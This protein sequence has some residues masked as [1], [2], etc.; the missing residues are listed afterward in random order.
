MYRNKIPIAPLTMCD[1]LLIVSECG[2]KTE[3][4]AAYINCQSIFNKC[5]LVFLDRWKSHE[6]EDKN[7]GHVSRKIPRK[8]TD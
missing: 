4:M 6:E 8:N 2:Y 7:T 3:L 1:D 5:Q